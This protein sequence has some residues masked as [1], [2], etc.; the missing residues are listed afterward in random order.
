MR[1]AETNGATVT[2]KGM[3]NLRGSILAIIDLAE[4]L[5]LPGQASNATSVVVVLKFGERMIGLL[6]DAVSDIITVTD[7]WR[8]IARDGKCRL[9]RLCRWFDYARSADHRYSF[10]S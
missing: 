7:E 9:L 6:V 8:Q 2:D 3:S 1:R 5:R 4:R 10:G